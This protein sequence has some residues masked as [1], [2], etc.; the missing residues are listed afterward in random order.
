MGS[1]VRDA[2]RETLEKVYDLMKPGGTVEEPLNL[3]VIFPDIT[4][5]GTRLRQDALWSMLYLAGYLTT[6]DT[7]LPDNVR[8]PRRLRVPNR[9]VAELYRMEMAPSL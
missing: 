9:E 5:P 6:E 7:E 8:I 2:D 3:G 1:L 4:S